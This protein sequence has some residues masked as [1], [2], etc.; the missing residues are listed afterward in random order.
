MLF[1]QSPLLLWKFVH[2]FKSYQGHKGTH[3]WDT[4]KHGQTS[5]CK[6]TF[7]HKTCEVYR[8]HLWSVPVTRIKTVPSFSLP[9]LAGMVCPSV[10]ID[11]AASGF[12][13]Q[14]FFPNTRCEVFWVT[15]ALSLGVKHPGRE[16]NHSHACSS[17]VKNAWSCTSTPQY[18]FMVRC[19]VK[20]Q[21]YFA[22]G[23]VLVI[24][25]YN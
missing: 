2:L 17:E 6:P 24:Y 13:F 7:V 15:G 19:S 8:F 12:S 25:W 21:L 22:E 3:S 4:L 23:P 1:T 10:C 14:A 18:A 11:T 5:H 9:V 20:A 16:V